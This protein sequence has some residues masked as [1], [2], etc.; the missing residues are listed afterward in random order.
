M[1]KV[2]EVAE[3]EQV[4]VVKQ[5]HLQVKVE[6][7]VLVHQVQYHQQLMLE[8]VAEEQYQIVVQE[9][10]QMVPVDL[11]EQVEVEEVL[12]VHQDQKLE[13]LEQ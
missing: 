4:H 6:M 10:F 11:V 13:Q 8:E 7:V 9:Q 3:A 12:Q 5:R 1:I 2:Q